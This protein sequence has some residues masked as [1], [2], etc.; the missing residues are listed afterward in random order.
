MTRVVFISDTH[1]HHKGINIPEG[2]VLVHAGDALS[3]GTY[4]EGMSFISWWL[5]MVERFE[6]VIYSPG[7]HDRWFEYLHHSS[8]KN[9]L[10]HLPNMHFLAPG[11]VEI[12]GLIF[13]GDPTTPCSYWKRSAFACPPLGHN[14]RNIPESADV[15]I[16]HVPPFE[17]LDATQDGF[18]PG[19]PLLRDR[20][21]KIKP[22]VHVFGH[23]HESYGMIYDGNTR[24]I[25]A[26]ICDTEYNPTKHAFLLKL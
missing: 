16:T 6:H 11:Q 14:W 26:S 3:F 21:K 8:E 19:C 12:N 1:G 20:I 24:F 10:N 7:N 13:Y 4:D 17:I 9:L 5:K 18:N 22:K 25:N 15:V 23:I 2:D